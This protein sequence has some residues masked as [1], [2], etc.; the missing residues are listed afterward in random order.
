MVGTG[1]GGASVRRA[2]CLV[3]AMRVTERLETAEYW[4]DPRFQR[5]K[6]EMRHNWVAASGD[7]IYEPI[8][9]SQWRQLN[10]YHSKPDGTP[11]DQ[12]KRRDTSVERI[13]VSDDYVYYGGE[14]PKLLKRFLSGGCMELC[15]SGQNYRRVRD[16]RVIDDFV[17][18][19]R[20]CGHR[21]FQGKPW[22][23]VRRRR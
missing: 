22:D 15:H 3:Y 20:L 8:G 9:S 18:W 23:W 5:K 12:H 6:P 1:S 4:D 19:L 16:E 11:N 14:G 10:S 2:G 17:K 21:G 13:L 7:N